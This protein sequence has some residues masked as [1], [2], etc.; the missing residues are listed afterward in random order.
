MYNQL[1]TDFQYDFTLFGL[2]SKSKEYKLAW[3]LNQSCYCHFVK[4]PDIT[5]NS[6]AGSEALFSHFY[7]QKG[8]QIWRLLKNQ[9]WLEKEKSTFLLPELHQWNFLLWLHD[10]GAHICLDQLQQSLKTIPDINSFSQISVDLLPNKD[11][12]LF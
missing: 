5:L 4:L 12:L 10:P 6:N 2:D 9:A 8:G 11:N 1:N 3:V 7:F